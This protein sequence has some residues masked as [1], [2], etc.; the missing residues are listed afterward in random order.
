[1]ANS[2]YAEGPRAMPPQKGNAGVISG[3]CSDGFGKMR[4]E[5]GSVYEGD[6][7]DE[8]M[9]GGGTYT[10]PDGV[11]WEGRWSDGHA[12]GGAQGTWRFPALGMEVRGAGPDENDL[13]G[14]AAPARWIA[15]AEAAA[16]K[17]AAAKG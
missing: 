11:S 4:F 8:D 2:V 9:E 17:L 13:W 16:A 6:W 12:Q 3:N 5:D 10:F 1:M 14:T 15:A 7:G